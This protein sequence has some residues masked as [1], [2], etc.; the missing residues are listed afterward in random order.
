M[1][2]E[3]KIPYLNDFIEEFYQIFKKEISRSSCH[4]SVVTNLTSVH[5]DTGSITG[6]AQCVRD[7]GSP[8][9]VVQVGDDPALLW[10]WCRLGAVALILPIAWELLFYLRCSPKKPKERKREKEKEGKRK[11]G[12]K[13]G[14]KEGRKKGRNREG[15]R[16]EGNLAQTPPESWRQENRT[17][18]SQRPV[19]PL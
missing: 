2:K 17:I 8:W 18:H 9:T 16:K 1:E 7:P 3:K 12:G 13:E 4:G 14:R 6:L 15:R 19:L 11:K 5:E 10:L